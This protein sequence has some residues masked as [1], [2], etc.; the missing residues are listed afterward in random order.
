MTDK[1]LLIC[2]MKKEVLRL[3]ED[4]TNCK[5]DKACSIDFD[6]GDFLKV[7]EIIS[8][9]KNEPCEASAR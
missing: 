4:W 2:D 6:G 8:D 7:N 3:S 1:N 5:F 9:F